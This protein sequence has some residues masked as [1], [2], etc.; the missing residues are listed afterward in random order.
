[1]TSDD[2]MLSPI[3]GA[4]HENFAG[5]EVDVMAAGETRVKRLVYAVGGK[6]STHIRPHAGTEFCMHA[7]VGFLARGRLAGEYPDGC[8]FDF[9]APSAVYI[10]PEHD[11]WV[12]GDEPAVLIQFDYERDTLERLGIPAKHQH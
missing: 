9:A 2:P 1:M 4:K 6:W 11:S 7:H 12:V 10:E 5:V 8:A 3:D